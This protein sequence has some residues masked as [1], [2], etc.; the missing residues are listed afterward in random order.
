[1]V[2]MIAGTLMGL[3]GFTQAGPAAGSAAAAL[4]S[5]IAIA[6]GGGVP[7]GSAFS[8]VQAAAMGG[9]AVSVV[10]DAALVAGMVLL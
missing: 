3:A 6:S 2:S 10:V 1:M 5:A 9:P 8:A 7:A 4:Q